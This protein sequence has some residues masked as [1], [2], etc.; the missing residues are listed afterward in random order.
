MFLLALHRWEN[1]TFFK[2]ETTTKTSNNNNNNNNDI[3][4]NVHDACLLYL[5]WEHTVGVA[6]ERNV[7]FIISIRGEGKRRSEFV[8]WH[9]AWP[10]SH[11]TCHAASSFLFLPSAPF[12]VVSLWPLVNSFEMFVSNF[13]AESLGKNLAEQRKELRK[14]THIWRRVW[15]SNPG[16]CSLHNATTAL[17]KKWI[18]F[19]FGKLGIMNY[20]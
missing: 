3:R 5:T 7:N 6:S 18:I 13:P 19:G 2:T 16:E 9:M 8:E 1:S 11:T 15:E 14:S 12:S 10:A 17:D 20:K 4:P